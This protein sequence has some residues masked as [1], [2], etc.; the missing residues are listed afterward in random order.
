MVKSNVHE[1]G[2]S[3]LFLVTGAA[4]ITAEWGYREG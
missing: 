2:K 3:A 4:K 1:A